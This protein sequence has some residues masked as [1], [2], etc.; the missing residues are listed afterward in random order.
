MGSTRT[1]RNKKQW[2]KCQNT[3]PLSDDILK[4]IQSF[5]RAVTNDV[6]GNAVQLD[7]WHT[8]IKEQIPTTPITLLEHLQQLQ[9]PL[10]MY[11]KHNF[12][13]FST[14]SKIQ[15]FMQQ[16]LR[17][18]TDASLTDKKGAACIIIETF[19]QSD[20][21]TFITKVPANHS[22][23]HSNDSHRSELFGILA[24]ATMV[25]MLEKITQT[26]VQIHLAC[27][28]LRAIQVTKS[29]QYVN[30]RQQHFDVI[31]AILEKRKR[32]NSQINYFHVKGHQDKSKKFEDLTRLEQ[33]NVLCDKYAKEANEYLS[34]QSAV[35]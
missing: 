14:A 28:N 2:Y 22:G 23:I 34:P 21:I 31:R 7:G 12:D 16:K 33:L 24:S 11:P 5:P 8:C 1:S 6:K 3:I 25:E 26:S 10:W 19:D 35:H 30:T 4:Q 18:V 17:I 15:K 9:L 27:D 20:N 32:I 29:I 13:N